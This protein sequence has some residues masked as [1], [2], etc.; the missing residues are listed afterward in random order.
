LTRAPP[1]LRWITSVLAQNVTI[2][3]ARVVPSQNCLPGT[4]MFPLGGTGRANS[5]G[6]PR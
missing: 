4:S 3:P 6:P 1:M 2:I 5:T